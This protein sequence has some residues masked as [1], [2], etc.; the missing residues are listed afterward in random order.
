MSSF[1]HPEYFVTTEWLSPP[2][3]SRL[4]PPLQKGGLT[5]EVVRHLTAVLLQLPHHRF[6][7][8]NILL[9][10]AISADIRGPI[11]SEH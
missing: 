11:L 2:K 5:F 3:T 8:G 10:R 9:G 6:M 4:T 7:K 1:A